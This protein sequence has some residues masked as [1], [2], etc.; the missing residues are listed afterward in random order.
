[1]SS[2]RRA[3]LVFAAFVAAIFLS[4]A[5]GAGKARQ[6]PVSVDGATFTAEIKIEYGKSGLAITGDSSSVAH[7]AILRQTAL[8]LFP[9]AKHQFELRQRRVMPPGWAL[10]TELTLRA[11]AQTYSST[12]TIDVSKVTVRGIT[13]QK[14]EWDKAAAKLEK[15]LPEGTVFQQEVIELRPGATLESQCSALI[16]S[17]LQGR[18]IEFPRDSDQLSSNAY[19]VLDELIQ[20]VADCPAAIVAITGHTDASGDES[21]NQQL[22]EARANSVMAYMIAGGISADRLQAIGAG[23]ATPMLNENNARARQINRR[24]EIRISFR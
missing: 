24:I 2:A 12:A 18:K 13:T 16:D 8:N 5:N 22:S 9:Q 14:T 20:I 23:S 11:V 4:I 1:M 7:E 15:N 6:Q 17:A 3:P 21:A 19:A 10:L